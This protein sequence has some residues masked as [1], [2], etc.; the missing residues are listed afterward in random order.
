MS[1]ESIFMQANYRHDKQLFQTC[2]NLID[3]VFPGARQLFETG[4]SIGVHLD[5][6]STPFI[7]TIQNSPIAHIG[8]LTFPIR[9]N[10]KKYTASALHAVCTLKAHRHQGY[11]KQLM[12][13]AMQYAREISD[14]TVLYTDHPSLYSSYGFEEVEEFDYLLPLNESFA[15]NQQL[16]LLSLQNARDFQTIRTLYEGHSPLSDKLEVKSFELFILNCLDKQLY[17]A[18]EH[19][20][21]LVTQP[22]TVN[23]IK[24]QYLLCS[25]KPSTEKLLAMIPAN[26][27]QVVFQMDID[28]LN[29]LTLQPQPADTLGYV[30]V[31]HNMRN[32]MQDIRLPEVYRC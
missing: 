2:C 29:I 19:D 1:L 14:F 24:I 11:F 8:V 30:M 26:V 28:L 17:Y 22:P 9:L 10:N 12:N 25:K 32:L 7:I 15:G 31:N 13:E 27:R 20:V 18:D 16:R 5:N 3:T 23:S 4:K 6:I 21:L